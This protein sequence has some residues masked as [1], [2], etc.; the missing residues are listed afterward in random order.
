MIDRANVLVLK[1]F[2]AASV[3]SER[4]RR[5]EG[6]TFVE[7]ALVILLIAVAVGTLAAWDGLREAITTAIGDMTEAV[8]NAGD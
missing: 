5:E 7:Y 8:S 1:L 6:Q 3:D 4:L 2:S